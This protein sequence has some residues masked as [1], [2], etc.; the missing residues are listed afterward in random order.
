[1]THDIPLPTGWRAHGRY[2]APSSLLGGVL[3]RQGVHLLLTEG[4]SPA[5][6]A[7]ALAEMAVATASSQCDVALAGKAGQRRPLAGFIGGR[8]DYQ[9]QGVA[10]TGG[11]PGGLGAALEATALAHGVSRPLDIAY[12]PLRSTIAGEAGLQRSLNAV[13]ESFSADIALIVVVE[14]FAGDRAGDANLHRALRILA[15]DNPGAAILLVTERLPY[16]NLDDGQVLMRLSDD[17]LACDNPLNG[18]PFQSA[19]SRESIALGVDGETIIANFGPR[20]AYA[21]PA[22]REKEAAPAPVRVARS[23]QREY[24]YL[25]E[26]QRRLDPD[27]RELVGDCQCTTAPLHALKLAAQSVMGEAII[28]I[29]PTDR[30]NDHRLAAQTM[31]RLQQAIRQQG[32]AQK[33]SV[34]FAPFVVRAF[35]A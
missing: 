11:L 5:T 17:R 19:I 24:V 16:E 28:A 10:L 35:A 22:R 27:E 33:V 18:S 12:A 31:N 34:E 3:P 21:P 20:R 1:M 23:E 7:G 25:V 4:A 14:P 8:A 15:G 29:V 9:P 13:A 6:V 2:N 26:T 30:D 32:L